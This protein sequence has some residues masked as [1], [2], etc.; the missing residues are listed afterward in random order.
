MDA[1][2]E[3][4]DELVL[5]E[6]VDQVAWITINNPDKANAISPQMRDRMAE[7]FESLNGQFDAR[8]VVLT[9]TG[10]RFFCTGADISVGREYAPRP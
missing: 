9:A 5:F 6:I 10:D 8:S 4:L 2:S 1:T 3:Q 7:I